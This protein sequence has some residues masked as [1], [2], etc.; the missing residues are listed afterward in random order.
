M[1]S[2]RVGN[3][4]AA[5]LKSGSLLSILF[6]MNVAIWLLMLFLPIA[7]YLY[8]LPS[9]SAKTGWYE[10][11]ALSSQW[12]VVLHRP[13][14]LLTYMFLH[15]GFWHILFNML[16]LYFG[17]TMCCR[18]LN[19]RRFGWI[20]LASGIVGALLY[21]LVYNLFPVGRLQVS[22]LV[23]ASAA[24]L[25]VFVAVAAYVPNQEV[26]LWLVR[27]FNIKLKWLAFIFVIIDLLS[28]PACNAGGHIAHIGGALFGWLF[29]IVMRWMNNRQ[30]PTLGRKK[31]K[32]LFSNRKKRSSSS[33]RSGRPL[34]DE[35]FNLRRAEEQKRIDAILDKIS[36]SGYDSLSKAEKAFLFRQK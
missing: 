35:E 21:L 7:D 22:M 36:K 11:L 9:G 15:D 29:V 30:G 27:T 14:T 6:I 17:G 8:A 34:S 24:V 13:W 16:M 32:P 18:Y 1:Q 31:R 26:S 25:G 4:F 23:G 3:E 10:W 2:Q 20:Y 5:F 33:G 28:I 12:D 19:S